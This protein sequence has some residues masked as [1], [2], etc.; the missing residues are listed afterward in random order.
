MNDIIDK[1]NELHKLLA[2]SSLDSNEY[3]ALSVKLI[4]IKQ[5]IRDTIII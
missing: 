3:Q 2:K 1:L 5:M 4:E